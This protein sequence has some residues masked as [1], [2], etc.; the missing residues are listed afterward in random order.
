MNVIH[1]YHYYYHYRYHHHDYDYDC[2]CVP[3]IM[4]M[5]IIIMIIMI[6]MIIMII[7]NTYCYYYQFYCF[8]CSQQPLL[9]GSG[10]GSG[11]KVPVEAK[12]TVENDRSEKNLLETSG[13][14]ESARNNKGKIINNNRQKIETMVFLRCS[15]SFA[16]V[17]SFL[18]G[19]CWKL[20]GFAPVVCS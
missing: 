1:Y 8:P 6:V 11:T 7:I 5:I 3:V 4:I 13:S 18:P 10:A 16:G 9:N 19:F 15:L 17:S 14:E 20:V 12:A 2:D